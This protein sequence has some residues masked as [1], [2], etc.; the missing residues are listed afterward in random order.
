MLGLRSYQHPGIHLI[1][2]ILALSHA[3]DVIPFDII[4]HSH[5]RISVVK[6]SPSIS[7]VFLS[8]D[9]LALVTFV[10]K[11]RDIRMWSPVQLITYQDP[12]V[13]ISVLIGM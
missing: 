3:V 4:V 9:L 2:V 6:V 7:L 12:Y 13:S 1:L 5:L 10:P 11:V 8:T